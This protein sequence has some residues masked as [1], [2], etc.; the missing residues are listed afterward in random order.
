MRAP[1]GHALGYLG[2][3]PTAAITVLGGFL[4]EGN[5]GEFAVGTDTL[6]P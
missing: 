3:V 1:G 2:G 4:S 5:G 6:N